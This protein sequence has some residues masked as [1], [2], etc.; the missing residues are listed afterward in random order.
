MSEAMREATL[1]MFHRFT[2]G[3]LGIFLGVC[4]LWVLGFCVGVLLSTF[5]RSF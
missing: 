5:S 1:P 4:L 3:D 2:V